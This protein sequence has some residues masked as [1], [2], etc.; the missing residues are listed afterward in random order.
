MRILQISPSWDSTPPQVYGP[1]EQ[2][3]SDLTNEL[4]R[5]GHQV[6]LFATGDSRTSATLVYELKQAVS[7]YRPK[8]RAKHLHAAFSLASSGS[9]DFIHNHE[10]G[11][12]IRLC[13]RL[14]TPYLTCMSWLAD[15]SIENFILSLSSDEYRRARFTSI[16]QRQRQVLPYLNWVGTVYNGIK[17]DSFPFR[18]QK[19]NFLLFL[20]R[21]VPEKG[22]D[23]AIQVAKRIGIPLVIAGVVRAEWQSFFDTQILPHVD[24]HHIQWV[25]PAD[26]TLKRE[27][28]SRA[29][30]L[31][32][33]V[34]WE[35]PFGLVMIEAMAC[36]T[37]VI[38]LRQGAVSEIIV[39]GK[40]GYIADT[41]EDMCQYVD[42]ISV[43]QALA[44]RIHVET[45][46]SVQVMAQKYLKIYQN[47]I[48][49]Q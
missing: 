9:F 49:D 3:A 31:L 17:V 16:S 21:I 2:V 13:Q 25:G 43:L 27:L 32:M 33:P 20:G 4:V 14:S 35:E 46:F 37:P 1:L 39:H 11:N 18:N 36:G 34:R 30:A 22:P 6:T 19:D 44:C 48:N 41:I 23:I 12:G 26:Q 40:T 10:A 45:H 29:F 8:I 42:R 15:K 28:F 24:G 47:V 7:E 5:L 38:A